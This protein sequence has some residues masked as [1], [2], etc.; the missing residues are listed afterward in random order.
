MTKQATDR[1]VRKMISVEAPREQAFAVFAA[2]IGSWWP[3]ESK[4]IGGAKAQTTVI[5]PST[6][7]RW[8]ERG[9]DG[10]ECDWGRVLVYEPPDR[11][12]LNW[13]ISAD[14]RYDRKLYT[15]VDVRFIG[16]DE[17]RTRIE[18]EHRGLL[19]AYGDKAEEMYATLDSPDGWTDILDRYAKAVSA[20]LLSGIAEDP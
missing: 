18:F 20:R 5:E 2:Q 12:V 3:L 19:D 8:F 14:W 11:L 4:K 1:T 9:V 17:T 16:E 13:Q 10:S 15:E 7:G 6:G